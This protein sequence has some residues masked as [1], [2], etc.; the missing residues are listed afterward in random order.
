MF[1][2]LDHPGREKTASSKA[3][4]PDRGV[5]PTTTKSTCVR[6]AANGYS[7]TGRPRGDDSVLLR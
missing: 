6:I 5:M 3:R 4:G 7:R 2:W 1:Q